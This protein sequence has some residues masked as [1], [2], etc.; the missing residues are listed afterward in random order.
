MDRHQSAFHLACFRHRLLVWLLLLNFCCSLFPSV[1]LAQQPSA[2]IRSLTGNVMV[3]GQKARVGTV[4]YAGAS[5]STWDGASALLRL[6]DGSEIQIGENTQINIDDLRQTSAGGRVSGL[7]MLV[8]WLRATL[9]PDHQRADSAFT[10][11]T[12][13]AQIGTRFSEP[14]FSVYVPP[15]PEQGE[16]E[17]WVMA[18][19]V[20]LE[21]TNRANGEM[22]VLAI[23]SSAIVKGMTIQVFPRILDPFEGPGGDS[24]PEE[25]PPS[26]GGTEAGL[27]TGTK[28]LIGAGALAVAGG[29][30]AAVIIKNNEDESSSDPGVTGQCD[31]LQTAG[32]DAR[33]THIIE[34]GKRSGTFLFAYQT[35][36]IEDRMVIRYE[37]RDLFDTGC[38]GTGSWR[39]RNI[40]Y[41]GKSS[42]ITVEVFPNCRGTSGTLWEFVVNCP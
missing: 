30:A 37:N 36:G 7:T 31:Q 41:S 20:E 2:T 32:S 26:S 9:S 10:V 27:G 25:Q 22:V 17:T 40:S 1:S 3:S 12:P 15:T 33:E 6:S 39:E 14:H 18:D 29:A 28:V 24:G 5:I 11:D 38:V 4:L 13:N 21:V 34:L 16:L 8:G 23:G 19:N 42:T 35:Y